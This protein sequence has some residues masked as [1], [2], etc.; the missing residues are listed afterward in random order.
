MELRVLEKFTGFSQGSISYF[1]DRFLRAVKDN[2]VHVVQWPSF[3]QLREIAVGFADQRAGV[4]SLYSV[5]GAIDGPHIRISRPPDDDHVNYINRKGFW[6]VQLLAIVDH[7][8]RFTYISTGAP[9][10]VHD[11][12]L[13]RTSSF[14]KRM[15]EAPETVIPSDMYILG[16]Q[17]FAIAPWLMVPYENHYNLNRQC[18]RF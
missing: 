18:K 1:T 13:L 6:S 3:H 16:D 11:Q 14:W 9:G 5:A 2:L 15:N 10:A 7:L 17:G 4:R 12:R 8:E